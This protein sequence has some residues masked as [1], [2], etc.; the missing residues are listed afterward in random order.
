[1]Q[2]SGRLDVAAGALERRDVLVDRV[3]DERVHEPQRLAGEQYVDPGEGV[4]GGR[5]GLDHKS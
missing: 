2:E 5:G 3:P 4:G 1:V